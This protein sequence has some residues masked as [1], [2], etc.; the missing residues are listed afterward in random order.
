[1]PPASSGVL[2]FYSG[3]NAE[4]LRCSAVEPR[5]LPIASQSTH[6]GTTRF[7]PWPIR[8]WSGCP[9]VRRNCLIFDPGA[10]TTASGVF[11]CMADMQTFDK[12]VK[13]S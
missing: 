12:L 1:M 8:G 6:T 10:V 9:A 5:L 4:V 11:L 2:S 7:F 13:V 3:V